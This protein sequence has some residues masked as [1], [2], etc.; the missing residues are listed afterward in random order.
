MCLIYHTN[1]FLLR[2]S[3]FYYRLIQLEG[4]FA[5]EAVVVTIREDDHVQMGAFAKEGLYQ[6]GQ[7]QRQLS[8]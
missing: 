4:L 7:L 5:P 8:K 1:K 3:H 2:V 6:K